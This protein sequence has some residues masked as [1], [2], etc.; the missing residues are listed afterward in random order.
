MQQLYTV[1]TA[2][3]IIAIIYKIVQDFFMKLDIHDFI[4]HA[5]N[6]CKG[7]YYFTKVVCKNYISIANVHLVCNKTFTLVQ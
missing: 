3:T 1:Y 4:K 2:Y 7:M 6:S 5:N